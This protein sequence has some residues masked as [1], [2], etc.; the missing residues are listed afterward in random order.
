MQK[1]RRDKDKELK[2]LKQILF[3]QRQKSETNQK[4]KGRKILREDERKKKIE[5]QLDIINV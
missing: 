5:S 3:F 2:K 4:E 1:R